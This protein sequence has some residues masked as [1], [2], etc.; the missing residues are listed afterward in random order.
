[1]SIH[2]LSAFY[3]R[4]R[5]TF[6]PLMLSEFTRKTGATVRDVSTLSRLGVIKVHETR[7]NGATLDI[8]PKGMALVESG[9]AKPVAQ[10]VAPKPEPYRVPDDLRGVYAGKPA[11]ES[12][13]ILAMDKLSRAERRNGKL[14]NHRIEDPAEFR[15]GEADTEARLAVLKA[16]DA[17]A[18]S[19]AAVAEAL[20][21][22]KSHTGGRVREM[23]RN[24]LLLS[25][26]PADTSKPRTLSITNIARKFMET[27]E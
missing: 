14:P 25:D 18:T 11:P 4:S 19:I 27:A 9:Q 26:G 2:Q 20:G 13:I 12:A 7:T 21:K 15:A 6:V 24:G 8:T 5:K 23:I 17:G 16:V 1:M 22:D 10:P 3:H